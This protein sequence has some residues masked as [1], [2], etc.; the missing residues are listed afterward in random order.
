MRAQREAR[1]RLK[2]RS[3]ES[4][5]RLYARAE[6]ALAHVCEDNGNGTTAEAESVYRETLGVL[7]RMRAIL[8]GVGDGVFVTDSEGTIRLWNRAAEQVIGT[9]ERRAIGATCTRALALSVRERSLSHQTRMLDCSNGC[10]LLREFGD[11]AKNGGVECVRSRASANEQQLLVSV[12]VVEGCQGEVSEVVHSVRDITRLKEADDAKTMF[13]ATASHEL[14]TPLT[15]IL[16][17]TQTLLADLLDD[18]Q[19][20]V[21]LRSIESRAQQLARIVDRLLLTGRIEAGRVLLEPA[22]VAL[23]PVITERTESLA[24][25]TGRTIVSEMSDDISDVV[26]DEQALTTV[27][28]HLLDNAVKYSPDGGPVVVRAHERGSSVVIEITDH[29]IGMGAD[30]VAQCF[31]RFWQAEQTDVRR[32]G[33]TGVGL[34]IVKSYIEGMGGQVGVRSDPGAGS[35]F[36]V[37]LKKASEAVVPKDDDETKGTGKRSMIHEFMKQLGVPEGGGGS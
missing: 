29:G 36:T 9:S 28:D 31:D 11:R 8:E 4:H 17:Y 25:A 27:L 26:A 5:D 18:D 23:R 32:F 7:R 16:G 34:Y 12:S 10:A 13:L 22:A 14:K 3:R 20:E 24:I 30:D 19:K 21:A 2:S 6:S 1:L 35:V 15:V 33:G 37:T